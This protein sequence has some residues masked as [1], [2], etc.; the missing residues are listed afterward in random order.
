M[1]DEKGVTLIEVLAGLAIL[2]VIGLV[3]WNV[4]FQGL[5]YSKKAESDISLQQEANIIS[6]K[7]TRIHQTSKS[8]SVESEQCKVKVDYTPSSTNKPPKETTFSHS[9]LCI[10]ANQVDKVIPSNEEFE[11]FLT[12]Y[13]KQRPENEFK[14]RTTLY[15][16][17]EG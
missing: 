1:T 15:R 12:I 4:F 17:R 13:D 10:S 8:Y 14:L 2:T 6:M 11:L 9:K 16:L 7:M 3:L 5:Y